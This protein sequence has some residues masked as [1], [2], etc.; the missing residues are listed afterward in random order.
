MF[1]AIICFSKCEQFPADFFTF[2]KEILKGQFFFAQ[3]NVI[4]REY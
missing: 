3:R 4:L 1:P 2:T